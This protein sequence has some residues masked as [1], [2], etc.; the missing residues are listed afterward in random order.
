MLFRS[1]GLLVQH[2]FSSSQLG[3][4]SKRQVIAD[5]GKH[6]IL[7]AGYSWVAIWFIGEW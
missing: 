3:G 5:I 1:Q 6:D 7:I 2:S 4:V